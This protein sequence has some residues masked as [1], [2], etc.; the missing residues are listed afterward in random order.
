MTDES[1]RRTWR[2]ALIG[3]DHIGP[4]VTEA[5]RTVL[6]AVAEAGWCAF[7][8][9]E[10]PWGAKHYLETG[11]PMDRDAVAL[12]KVNDAILFG[13]H[14]DPA[15]VPEH[16]TGQGMLHRLR[17]DLMASVNI[18]PVRSLPGL[19]TPLEDKEPIDLVVVRENSEGA[20]SGSAVRLHQGTPFEVAMQP[21]VISRGATERVAT[22]A[23][24]L[25]QRRRG[26]VTVAT[27]G[28]ALGEV[29]GVWTETIAE[30]SRRFDD[31]TVETYNVDALAMYL[32]SRPREFD[33]VLA[34]NAMGDILSDLACAVGGGIGIAPS[35]SVDPSRTFPGLF[36]PVHGSAPDIAGTGKANPIGAI[37]SAAMML[38]WLGEHGAARAIDE[39]VETVIRD[40]SRRTPDLGGAGSTSACAEAI[41][42]HIADGR[43][44]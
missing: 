33:V 24:E 1:Q 7:E 34:T 17:K 23:F 31:V 13:A 40:P 39:A 18:R 3:G 15:R 5:A 28:S 41:A 16:I 43:G 35:G 38:E 21:I 30:V 10:F 25:A 22:F 2:I 6:G 29:L 11:E 42:A 36:E 44:R 26:K 4:E 9:D 32:V 8:F 19:P 27:K 14:G 12:L 37:R 20:Y